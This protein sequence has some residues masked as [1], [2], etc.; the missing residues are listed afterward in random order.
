MHS[1]EQRF[2]IIQRNIVGEKAKLKY[3]IDCIIYRIEMVVFGKA[4]NYL[5]HIFVTYCISQHHF[6]QRRYWKKK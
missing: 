2:R 5:L 4:K 1:D 6:S 3:I